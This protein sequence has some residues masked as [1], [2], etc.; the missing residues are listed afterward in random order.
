MKT[1]ILALALAL[2][3]TA[4]GAVTPEDVGD[5]DSF[6]LNAEY[7]G[8]ATTTTLYGLKDCSAEPPEAGVKCITLL[9]QPKTT[10]FDEPQTDSIKLPANAARSL[11]CF[12][13]TQTSSF[14]LQNQTDTTSTGRFQSRALVRIENPVLNGLIDPNTGEP[15]DG[16]LDLSLTVYREA[17][18]LAP[19]ELSQRSLAVTRSCTYGLVSKQSL[20]TT[21]GLTPEQANAFFA[22]PTSVYLGMNGEL[23]FAIGFSNNYSLRL[24]GDRR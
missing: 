4:A 3:T 12:A 7:P 23:D 14:A 17:G 1:T 16:H 18:T 2:A 22:A 21:Y 15:F 8:L 19:G 9:P 20:V 6:G 11:L 24:Y 10:A 13:L 5:A